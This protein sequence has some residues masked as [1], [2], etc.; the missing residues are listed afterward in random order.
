MPE[1]AVTSPVIDCSNF[2]NVTLTF[3]RWLGV[4]QPIYDHAYIRVSSDGSNWTTVWENASEITD[5]AW[6]QQ[7]V[8]VSQWADGQSTFQISFVMGTT[9]V[10]W[11]YCGWNIDDLEIGG[12]TCD[13]SQVG[14]CC[15]P[16][17]GSCV[18][19]AQEDC[20]N[21]G[22]VFK[23]IGTSCQ[24]D[25]DGDAFDGICD[26]CP[27]DYN[28]GQEDADEDLVGD[29]CDNC[30]DVYN[31]DQEDS[32]D[33]GVGDACETQDIPTLSEWGMIIMAL[34]LLAAGT[35]AVVRNRRKAHV[36]E[37]K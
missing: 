17:D 33:D 29:V 35:I 5:Y 9:D 15:Y 3:Y 27:D 14:A 28:P 7:N 30:P 37:N 8:N 32:D 34:L 10:G 22:G 16:D 25:S 36:T 21:S 12:Y 20:Q 24:G 1:R 18:E 11:R 6:Q 31:P 26:N 13:V 19:L 4:E 2:S 23:G